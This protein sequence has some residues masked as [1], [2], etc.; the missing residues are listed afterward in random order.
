VGV[1]MVKTKTV[2]NK[3]KAYEEEEEVQGERKIKISGRYF[4]F[5]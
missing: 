2:Q 1:R 5:S 3:E 4:Y